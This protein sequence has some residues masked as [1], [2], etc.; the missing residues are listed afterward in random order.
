VI[1]NNHFESCSAWVSIELSST[2]CVQHNYFNGSTKLFLDLY[3][4]FYT[5][6][7][8]RSEND[9]VGPSK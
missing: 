8:Y 9:F 7:T 5:K 6:K 4:N 3:L 1:F 2:F